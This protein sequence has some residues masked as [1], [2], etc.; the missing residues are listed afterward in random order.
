VAG[1]TGVIVGTAFGV[2]T[3][4]VVDPGVAGTPLVP[5]TTVLEGRVGVLPRP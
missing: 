1:V 3:F 2:V 4:D 5:A